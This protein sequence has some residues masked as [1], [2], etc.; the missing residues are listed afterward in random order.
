[1]A[2]TVV[3]MASGCSTRYFS[4]RSASASSEMTQSPSVVPSKVIT[5]ATVGR[6]AFRSASF[7][8]CTSSSAKTTWHSASPTMYAVSSSFVEG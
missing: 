6:S 1:M 8:I 7:L 5:L 3:L 4:P 2:A